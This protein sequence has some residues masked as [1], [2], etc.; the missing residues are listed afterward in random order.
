VC[1]GVAPS[2]ALSH[3]LTTLFGSWLRV[4]ARSTLQPAGRLVDISMGVHPPCTLPAGIG[5]DGGSQPAVKRQVLNLGQGCAVCEVRHRCDCCCL[6]DAHASDRAAGLPR[7]R[8]GM[9]RQCSVVVCISARPR[10]KR[11]ASDTGEVGRMM[12]GLGW[13]TGEARKVTKRAYCSFSRGAAGERDKGARLGCHAVSVGRD[14]MSEYYASP[15]DSSPRLRHNRGCE[16]HRTRTLQRVVHRPHYFAEVITESS[17]ERTFDT[18]GRPW[19]IAAAEETQRVRRPGAY[20]ISVA[21]QDKATKDDHQTVFVALAWRRRAGPA[22]AATK[23]SF[24][25]AFL[26]PDRQTL[27]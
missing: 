16:V 26:R 5:P 7:S 21:R 1:A 11:W 22:R 14:F 23:Q 2:R 17:N 19:R 25:E 15:S 10:R 27:L 8:T 24:R 13:A 9:V 12:R 6:R 18:E 20:S 4:S 3:T